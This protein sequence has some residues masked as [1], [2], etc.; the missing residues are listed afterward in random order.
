[1]GNEWWVTNKDVTWYNLPEMDFLM[2]G[3]INVCFRHSFSHIP[4]LLP[5][6]SSLIKSI[7]SS[8]PLLLLY[9]ISNSDCQVVKVT[10]SG[11]YQIAGFDI[12]PLNVNHPQ[13]MY[14]PAV[15]LLFSSFPSCILLFPSF[16]FLHSSFL[17]SF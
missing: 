4:S 3:A 10:E 9:N 11:D 6:S 5:S 17:F 13:G 16:S 7:H 14:V 1:M 8:L 15:P 12:F 2:R